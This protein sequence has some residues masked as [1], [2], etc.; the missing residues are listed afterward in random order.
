LSAVREDRGEFGSTPGSG[1]LGMRLGSVRFLANGDLLVVP[2]FKPG[3]FRISRSGKQRGSWTLEELEAS[4]LDALG[5][6]RL[7]SDAEPRQLRAKY[8]SWEEGRKYL[9]SQRFVVEDVLPIRDKAAIVAR[10]GTGKRARYYLGL[11]EPELEWYELPL[12]VGATNDRVRS[13][14][15][16]SAR[17]I[18]FLATPRAG[19]VERESNLFVVSTP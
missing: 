12:R 1:A 8:T 5:V 17:K 4:L 11:L 15:S 19:K 18:V 7:D 9:D 16:K 2:A 6:E 3:V 13:D 10:H 14:Y